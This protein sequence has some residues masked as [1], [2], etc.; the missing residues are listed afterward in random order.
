MRR[1]TVG[2]VRG[3]Q[4]RRRCLRIWGWRGQVGFEIEWIE[5]RSFE[6]EGVGLGGLRRRTGRKEEEEGPAGTLDRELETLLDL[7]RL[8]VSRME[9]PSNENR[10]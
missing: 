1:V 7:V 8:R 10:P 6:V 5:E 9:E 4:R 2:R 3:F